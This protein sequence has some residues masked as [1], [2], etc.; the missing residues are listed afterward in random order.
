VRAIAAS[1]GIAKMPISMPTL[2]ASTMPIPAGVKGIVLN[3]AATSAV[4]TT[5]EM[6]RKPGAGST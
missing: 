2:P 6:P 3:T 5:A 1:G 4:K